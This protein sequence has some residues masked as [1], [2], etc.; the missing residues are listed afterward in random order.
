[1]TAVGVIYGNEKS[2]ASF[3]IDLISIEFDANLSESHNWTNDVTT[4]PV[5]NGSTVADHIISLPDKITLTGF[6]TNAPLS[7]GQKS[8]SETSVDDKK[9]DDRVD[10][11]IGKLR[12]LMDNK[13]IVT[14]FTKYLVYPN[15]AI[16][17]I[18]FP[19]NSSSGDAIEVNIDFVKLN[20]VSTQTVKVP[21]GIS[22]KLDKK[23]GDDVK[24]KT[25]P[26]KAAGAKQPV[27][28]KA[29]EKYSSVLKSAKSSIEKYL[30][31]IK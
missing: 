5:E 18:S 6:I 3:G 30:E 25:E 23:S 13:M 1:M 12:D 27:D 16:T 15:M 17:A 24:K 22:K 14:V 8:D 10:A 31:G 20:L 9:V 21:A 28:Q 2:T 7:L 26:Q 4:N 11:A 29:T 19:R